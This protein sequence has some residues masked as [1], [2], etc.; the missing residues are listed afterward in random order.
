LDSIPLKASKLLTCERIRNSE[1]SSRFD[2]NPDRSRHN[3]L[4]WIGKC[5]KDKKV[6]SDFSANEISSWFHSLV[7][8]LECGRKI[9]PWERGWALIKSENF[10]NSLRPTAK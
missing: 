7:E 8:G 4:I 3:F 2:V 10:L 9:E 5:Q 6:R 1:I